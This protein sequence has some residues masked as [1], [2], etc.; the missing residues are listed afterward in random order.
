MN[1]SLTL[2]KRSFR[3]LSNKEQKFHVEHREPAVSQNVGKRMYAAA[4][5][6]RLT[7]DWPITITSSNAEI[8]VS[9]IATRSRMRQ[10]E[11]DDD[12]FRN[13]LWLLENNVIGD[14]GIRIRPKA[15]D[16]SGKLHKDL[17]LAVQEAWH[18]YLDA[19]NCTVTRTLDGIQVQRLAIRALARD[20]VILFRKHR[21]FNNPFGF[22]LEPIEVDRL[23]HWWNRPAVGTANEIEFGIEIDKFHAPLAYWILTRHPGDVFA[24]S[25][26]PRYRERVPA[27][28]I[29][30][31]WTIERAGQLIGMPLWPSISK[32]LHNLAGYEES[33]QIAARV[34]ANK[35]GWFK[36][37]PKTAGADE[38]VG[39]KDE[40]GNQI[41]NTEPGQWEKLPLGWDPVQNDPQHPNSALPQFLKA[42]LRGASAGSGIPYNSVASD[43]ES[44]N[45]SSYKAGMNDARDGFKYLQ[46]LIVRKLMRPWFRDWLTYAVLAGQIP[47]VTSMDIAALSK[48]DRWKPRRWAGLEP[49]KEVQA[50]IL[51]KEAGL[52]SQRNIIEE[53]FDRD[54]EDVFEEQEADKKLAAAH[55]LNFDAEVSIKKPTDGN[56]PDTAPGGT[57]GEPETPARNGNG[58]GHGALNHDLMLTARRF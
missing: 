43:L 31:I 13:M 51:A 53:D 42:Q 37:D 35:G 26:S 41:S 57:D 9:A 49:L 39:P 56:A 48:S 2:G 11:R 7:S 22:A 33:E 55:G 16:G 1:F 28:E 6:S 5:V 52:D 18:E 29:I 38:Y 30:A 40:Q 12:Y 27:D 54:I 32:R 8:F 58:N 4:Q 14:L 45:Y 44:I 46:G 24:Y 23:D 34:A 47:G 15:R 21:P 36:E 3:F 17:N 19:A 20:G 25:S 50:A 10:M